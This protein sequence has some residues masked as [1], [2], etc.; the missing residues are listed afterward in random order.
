[1]KW[2]AIFKTGTHTDANGKTREWKE[3]DL[4]EI[5]A[6]YDPLKHEAPIVIGHPK[7]NAPAYGWIEKLKRVGDTLYALP[8]QLASE[9]VE[10]VD[11][12]LFKKR[13]ISLYPDNTL[14]HVGFL[15]A[16]PPAIK[17]LP[18]VE[19]KEE[20]E[21]S[22]FEEDGLDDLIEE[23]PASEGQPNS[24]EVLK[25]TIKDYEEKLKKFPT[26]FQETLEALQAQKQTLEVQLDN[27]KKEMKLKAFQ[28]FLDEQVRE[29]NLLP[30]QVPLALKLY[31]VVSQSELFEF[32]DQTKSNP[33]EILKD[34]LK[35]YPK[36]LDMS[37]RMKKENKKK[38]PEPVQSSSQIITEE[39]RNQMKGQ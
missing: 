28:D 11:K 17:G 19:F 13:S 35:S 33:I 18:D 1:M 6:K 22:T 2:F 15:G 8:K 37:E 12:G 29:G 5:V 32:S 3:S 26:N 9:F 30:K 7:T 31:E 27:I 24:I 39:I 16:Q 36:T 23:P 21:T 25:K 20:S 10:M 34:Y 14:R 38:E 4:D